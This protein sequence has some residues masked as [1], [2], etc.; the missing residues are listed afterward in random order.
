MGEKYNFHG[1]NLR[2]LLTS[3]VPK[4]ATPPNFMEKTF[5]NCHK[6]TKFAKVFSLES[7]PLYG[8]LFTH[9]DTKN[10]SYVSMKPVNQRTQVVCVLFTLVLWKLSL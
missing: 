1:E 4:D 7:F 9:Y 8:M 10:L 6:T 2:G 3:A 5:A